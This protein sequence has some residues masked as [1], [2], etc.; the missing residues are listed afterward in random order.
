[1]MAKFAYYCLVLPLSY[2]PLGVL[3][4][5]TDFFFLI[6][7]T[8]F[9]YRKQVIEDNLKHSFPNKSSKEIKELKRQF[10][11]HFCDILAEGIKNLSI[12]KKE[13]SRRFIVKNPE[14]ME[15]LFSQNK[16]VILVSGHYNNWEWLITSQ[17]FLF[18]HQAMGIGMPMTSKF[19]DKKIN[20][21]RMRFGMKV[22]HAK[23]FKEEI[24]KNNEHPIAILTLAD[25]SPGD[26]TKAYWTNFLNQETAVL[27]GVEQMAHTN[28]FA[29]V[30]F[31]TRKVKRGHYEMELKLITEEPR[32]LQWGDI[33]ENHLHLLENEI[34]NKPE[35]W[36]WSHKRWKRE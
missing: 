13:L 35:F 27:F 33:T 26:S 31:V 25:Q 21:R 16:S 12:S 6:L 20:E 10:Y 36:V 32:N 15:K 5:F 4:I 9:P 8:I 11:L 14:I 22:I 19:W 17:S 3:Y 34:I 7:V 1:M 24:Q 28:D 30:F 2:L 18:K 29:V 23:N